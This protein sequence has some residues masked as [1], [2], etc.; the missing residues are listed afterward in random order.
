[1]KNDFQYQSNRAKKNLV[2][3]T[4]FSITMLFAGF[5]SAYIVSMGDSFWIKVNL[6]YEFYLSTI[7]ILVSSVTYY[8]SQ[9]ALKKDEFKK[10]RSYIS[11][12]L[13]FGL[14]FAIC[15]FIGY[16]KLISKG[17]MLN[18]WIIVNDGR[19]GDYYE[20]KKENE[21][22]EIINNQ[23]C[24]KGKKMSLEELKSLKDFAKILINN[25]YKSDLTQINYGI[26]YFLYYK[27]VPLTMNKGKLQKDNGEDL[28]KLEY[29]RLKFLAQNILDDR[30][31]FFVK[32]EMGKDFKLFYKGKELD[33]IDR[34]LYYENKELSINLNNKLL[35]GNKDT[36][37]AYFYI[38][39]FLH[40]LHVLAG[41]IMLIS[42]LI[43]SLSPKISNNNFVSLQAGAIFWHFLGLLWVYLLLF[44][45]FIH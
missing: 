32:G 3:V 13:I 15:Q 25:D 29:E 36:S 43:K 8:L 21:K 27:G 17:A 16:N 37:T 10:V 24:L 30:A 12:T 2:W 44:L 14:L 6:P 9:K 5:T 19:Y 23:Y 38:I 34:K 40:L 1:M 31:D 18:N 39:T 26:P 28:K 4:V 35:R 20:I 11:V 7:F 22:I 45:L 33:Y 42:L 41:I